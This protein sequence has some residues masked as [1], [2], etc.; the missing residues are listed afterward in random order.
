MEKFEQI[1]ALIESTQNDVD[2]FAAKGNASAG[3]RVRQAMQELKK[4]AQDL[5]L[6]VQEA[7][8]QKS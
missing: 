4:L 6:E 2:K 1:K 8:N 7:K 3:T 5:R